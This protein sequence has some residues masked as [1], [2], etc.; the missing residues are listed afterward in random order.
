VRQVGYLQEFI[1]A[2]CER[3]VHKRR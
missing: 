2:N 3:R 1:W